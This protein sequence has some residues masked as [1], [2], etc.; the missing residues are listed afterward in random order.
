MHA[1]NRS[2]N[3]E[4]AGRSMTGGVRVSRCRVCPIHL[5]SRL[6]A[7]ALIALWCPACGT[8][9]PTPDSAAPAMVTAAP[10]APLSEPRDDGGPVAPADTPAEPVVN[11]GISG[12]DP[13]A[14]DPLAGDSGFGILGLDVPEVDQLLS[15]FLDRVTPDLLTPAGPQLGLAQT[16]LERLCLD[17]DLPVFV[18]RQRYGN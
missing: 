11:A 6:A 18:C 14:D 15:L 9:S 1:K 8:L 17:S 4:R 10:P 7:L 13:P 5:P 12:G 3:C 2:G 16:F